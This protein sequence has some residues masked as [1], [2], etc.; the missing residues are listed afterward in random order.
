MIDCLNLIDMEPVND[1]FTWNNKRG[2]KSQIASR[3]DRFLITE[4]TLLEGW[5]IEPT[6]MPIFISYHW[7]V[8]LDIDLHTPTMNR[9]FHF[10]KFWLKHPNFMTK[11]KQWW[12]EMKHIG[13][14]IMYRFQ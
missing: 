2:S 3:L 9:P 8:C 12:Q 7:P 13:G 14:M 4:H 5:S 6:I 10:E 1:K 11:V